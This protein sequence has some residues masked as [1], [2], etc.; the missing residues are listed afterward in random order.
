[1]I[2]KRIKTINNLLIQQK[3]VAIIKNNK[4]KIKIK[5]IMADKIIFKLQINKKY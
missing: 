5:I 4:I 1:M 3:K 2:N